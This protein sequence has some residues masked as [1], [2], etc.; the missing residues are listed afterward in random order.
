VSAWKGI[1]LVVGIA[2]LALDGWDLMRT[3]VVPRAW[4]RGPLVSVLQLMRRTGRLCIS[5]IESFE[6][7]DRLLAAYEGILILFRLGMWLSVAL[8]GYALVFWGSGSMTISGAF[9]RSGSDIFTLGFAAPNGAGPSVIAFFAAASGLIIVAL[10]IAYLPALYDAFNRRETLVSLLESRAGSPAWGPELLARHHLIGLESELGQL[11]TDW[12]R[13]AADVAESHSTYPSLMHLRSPHATNSWIISLIAT[14][15]AAALQ[16]SLQPSAAP[17][18][19]RMCIRMGFSALRDIA[20]AQRIPYDPD[21]S[22]DSEIQLSFEDFTF[23]VTWLTEAGL[24]LERSREEAWDHFRGWRINYEAI[25]YR[26]TDLLSAPPAPWTPPR[27]VGEEVA[28]LYPI[29]PVDRQPGQ[30]KKFAG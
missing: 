18:S 10:Q 20:R 29:R 27:T 22:P 8:A 11:F 17:G 1:V 13:W 2:L 21:P 6:T 26:L 3:L 24:D 28:N 4:G 7:R 15:D 19:A 14:M 5:M 9:V 23:G 30:K 25:A 12:E 16:L